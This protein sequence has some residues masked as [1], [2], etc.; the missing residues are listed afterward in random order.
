MEALK[1]AW[2]WL[3]FFWWWLNRNQGAVFLLA[4]ALSL[5]ASFPAQSKEVT[6]GLAEVNGTKLEVWVE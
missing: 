3:R 6:S 5:F 1:C 2:E 4:F